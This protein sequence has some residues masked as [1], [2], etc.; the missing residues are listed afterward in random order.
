MSVDEYFTCPFCGHRATV[1]EC[2]IACARCSLFGSGGCSKVR[3]PKCGYE[4]APPARLP[5]LL[6]KLFEKKEK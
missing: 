3:C 2:N 4:T 1:E 6:A 5:K